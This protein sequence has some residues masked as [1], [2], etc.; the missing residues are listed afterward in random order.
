MLPTIGEDERITRYILDRKGKFSRES[1]TVSYKAFLPAPDGDTSVFRTSAMSDEDVWLVGRDFVAGP[2]DRTVYARADISAA[3]I[4]S[5]GLTLL[6]DPE[7]HY[8]HANI[9]SW[10]KEKDER[11]QLA[12]ELANSSRL[13]IAPES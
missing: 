10:P 1:V 9:S 6:P 13:Q 11:Q 3:S 8:A 12:L 4:S 2:Q 5:T 7:P